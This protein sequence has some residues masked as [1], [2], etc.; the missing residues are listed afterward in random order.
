MAIVYKDLKISKELTEAN[1]KRGIYFCPLYTNTNEFLRKEITQKDL[2]K[3]FDNR[4]DSLVELWKEK[5]AKKRIEK[6]K[7]NNSVS[8]DLL[9]YS[10]MIY[11]SWN[12]IKEKYNV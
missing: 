10:D 6:L 7:E 2:V 11:L 4:F 12:E 1:H 9:F 8:S 5:Y 3:R